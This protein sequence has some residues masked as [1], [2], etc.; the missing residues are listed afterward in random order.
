MHNELVTRDTAAH[1]SRQ[2]HL[3]DSELV[4]LR[5]EDGVAVLS[6]PLGVVE[7]EVGVAHDIF[8]I[9]G[10][11]GSVGHTN[12]GTYQELGATNANGLSQRL[13]HTCGN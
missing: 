5:L 12:T 7:R 2:L 9:F 8:N 1:V 6:A 3:G 10:G 11:A 4:H 13:N